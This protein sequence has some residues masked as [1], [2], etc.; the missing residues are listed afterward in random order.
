MN[1]YSNN[2][3]LYNYYNTTVY[4]NQYQSTF[5]NGGYIQSTFI[6]PKGISHPPL[7]IIQNGKKTDYQTDK[8]SLFSTN[9]CQTIQDVIPK[10]ETGLLDSIDASFAK[11]L[12]KYGLN[13]QEIHSWLVIQ[14]LPITN[15]TSNL[16][17]ILLLQT[18]SASGIAGVLPDSL[19]Q[20]ILQSQNME[21]NRTWMSHFMNS[22]SVSININDYLAGYSNEMTETQYHI[23]ENNNVVLIKKP[24]LSSFIPN[25]PNQVM[26]GLN[27]YNIVGS[28]TINNTQSSITLTESDIVEYPLN[29]GNNGGYKMVCDDYT[30]DTTNFYYHENKEDVRSIF[31]MAFFWILILFVGFQIIMC[32]YWFNKH[33]TIETSVFGYEFWL[34]NILYILLVTIFA[35]CSLTL[36]VSKQYKVYTY[37]TTIFVFF[38]LWFIC[39]FFKI[40]YKKYYLCIQKMNVVVIAYLVSIWIT[41]LICGFYSESKL[42]FEDKN[43]NHFIFYIITTMYFIMAIFCLMYIAPPTPTP[44]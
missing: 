26:E 38:C 6:H 13:R 8:I 23:C 33:H 4:K 20:W 41:L 44:T 21:S 5:Q 19:D 27:N 7:S 28:K 36:I 40:F 14:H 1:F 12:E 9:N 39:E 16:Y 22:G 2:Q 11:Y 24:I 32:I 43:P 37:N 35:F 34:N 15:T 30:P 42:N 31:F 25:Q 29:K 3:I 10:K 17:V 18:N